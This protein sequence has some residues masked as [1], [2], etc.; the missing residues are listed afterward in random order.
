MRE[1]RRHPLVGET[2]RG[3]WVEKTEM[4]YSYKKVE[5]A[6][7]DL[8]GENTSLK[9]KIRGMLLFSNACF[10][11]GVHFL[12]TKSHIILHKAEGR[13]ASSPN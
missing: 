11:Y 2:D 3:V 4:A 5:R 10:F 9:E 12:S 6:N 8:V 1:G 13:A 7:T